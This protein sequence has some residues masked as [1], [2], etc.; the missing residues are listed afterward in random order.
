MPEVRFADRSAIVTGSGSGIGFEIARKLHA[1]GAWVL[2]ADVD[3]SSVPDG[4]EPIR[5]DVA[6]EP[7]V[8]AMIARAVDARG[9]LD[10]LCNNAGIASVTDVVD[11]TAEEWDRVFA[12]NARGVFLGCH[13]GVRQMLLQGGGVIVNTASVAGLV[14]LP[15]RAAYCASKGA[16]VALTKQIAVQYAK[17]GI[18]CN[19]V[20]PGTVDSPWVTRLLAQSDDPDHARTALVQRQPLG[21][22]AESSEIADAVLYLAS[23]T[24][25]FITGSA[26][27]IDGGLT[28]A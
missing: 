20:C 3:T 10:L 26:L 15:D 28:A 5:V 1:E 11:C 18:R 27:V 13:H 9:R 8:V 6:H 17:Q 24:A 7:D 12:V 21:R 22:L 2:A 23:D 19:C 4:C 16:V 14:G 25:A